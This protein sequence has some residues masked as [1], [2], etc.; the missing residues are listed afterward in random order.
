LRLPLL[1]VAERELLVLGLAHQRLL[2]EVVVARLDREHRL[3]L[4]LDRELLLLLELLLQ[5]LLVGDGDGHLLLGLDHLPL[6]VEQHLVEHLLRIFRLGDRVVD[7]R[8]EKRSEPREDRHL[9]SRL[10]A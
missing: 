5:A 2:G 9:N 8:L 10:R 3:L 4:P 1:F 7:V 6:H